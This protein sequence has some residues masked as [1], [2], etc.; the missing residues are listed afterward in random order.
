MKPGSTRLREMIASGN[1][2]ALPGVYD[3]LS[4][5]AAL[6]VGHNALYMTGAGTSASVLGMPDLGLLQLNDVVRNATMIASLDPTVP[7]IADADT[8]FGG[9][10]M[11]DRTARAYIRAGVAG[12]HIEDQVQSKRC[13][14]LASKQ[15]ASREEFLVRIRAA[16]NARASLESD[17]VIIARSDCADTLGWDE[18]I[19]RVK[20]GIKI[21]ADV[22]FI[23]GIQNRQ[24]AEHVVKS[25]A[26]TPMLLPIVA[27]NPGITLKEA[28]E[29]GFKLV[30]FGCAGFIPAS[31]ALQNSY[32]ECLTDGTD[33]KS[34]Q[35]VS[36]KD[37]YKMVGLESITKID[38]EAG[39]DLYANGV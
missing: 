25:M 22:G 8:G 26:P 23:E 28:E 13:G 2:V 6:S 31:I 20:E 32:R 24:E 3:G 30:I 12:F 39:S 17:I 37:F 1:I 33:K 27:G 35:G 10:T 38:T 36:A 5:R 15:F 4:A 14:A 21:G 29:I 19:W 16:V 34:C 9:G 11:N 18:A 7:V